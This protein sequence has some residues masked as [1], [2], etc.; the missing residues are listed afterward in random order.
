[1]PDI[2]GFAILVVGVIASLVVLVI[3]VLPFL[4]TWMFGLL[5]FFLFAVFVLRRGRRH[6]SHLPDLLHPWMAPLMVMLALVL[7]GTH[8]LYLA[9]TK[10]PDVWPWVLGFNATPPLAWTVRCLVRH[11]GDRRRFVRE[12]H[13]LEEVLDAVHARDR[14]LGVLGDRLEMTA[15]EDR[16]P[17]PWESV[18]GEAAGSTVVPRADVEAL[19]LRVRA[20]QPEYRSI[21]ASLQAAR[22]EVLSGD[23]RTLPHPALAKALERLGSQK[24]EDDEVCRRATEVLWDQEVA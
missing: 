4:A 9:F 7:P 18:A 1:M 19:L 8:G 24:H 14:A 10:D 21:A 11:L 3:W 2:A 23:A 20:L 6:P 15:S 22:E 16:Q 17:E 12:G 13:D 5:S